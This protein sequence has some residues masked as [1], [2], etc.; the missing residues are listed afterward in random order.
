[1]LPTVTTQR[2]YSMTWIRSEENPLIQNNGHLDVQVY[3]Q[4]RVTRLSVQTQT[5]RHS[6]TRLEHCSLQNRTNYHNQPIR[7]HDPSSPKQS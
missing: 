4:I 3:V 6:Q 1:M 7:S 5:S 2:I